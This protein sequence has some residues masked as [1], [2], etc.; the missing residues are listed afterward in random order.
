[1]SRAE[2]LRAALE[3]PEGEREI[4]VVELT[5]TLSEYAS[6]AVE[7]AWAEE[8]ERR[9]DDADAGKIGSSPW[10]EVRAEA[11]EAVRRARGR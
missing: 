9:I 7:K 3:L 10:S 8:I 5:A 2:I 6:P 4:L 11:S 1:M